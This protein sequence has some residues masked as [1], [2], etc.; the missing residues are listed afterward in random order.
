MMNQPVPPVD[1]LPPWR[2]H[3]LPGLM[4]MLGPLMSRREAGGWAY[5]IRLREEHLNQAGVVHGGTLAALM[6]HA[7][8]AIAW[9]HAGRTPCVTVQLNVNFLAPSRAGQLLVAQGH[10]DH[11]AGSLLFLNGSLRADGVLVGSAQGIMKR[12]GGGVRPHSGSDPD[13]DET[14]VG[15]GVRPRMGSD[16][17]TG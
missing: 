6:D 7:L 3:A 4:G 1:T 12:L 15:A 8:S 13:A 5:A 14:M 10:V 16:P 2:T 9:D 17:Q 11:E